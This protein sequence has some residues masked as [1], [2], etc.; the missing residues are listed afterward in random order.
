MGLS[1]ADFRLVLWSLA[2]EFRFVDRALEESGVS[3]L[4]LVDP[5]KTEHRLLF[6]LERPDAPR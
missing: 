4:V 1:P 2:P 6:V 3:N 5:F